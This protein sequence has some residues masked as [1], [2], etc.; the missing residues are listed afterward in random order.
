[1][2]LKKSKPEPP[3]PNPFL[4][5]P[6]R[7]INWTNSEEPLQYVKN[8]K[9]PVEGQK[10]RVLLY[11]PA[12]AGKSSFVNS[13]QSVLL[14]RM[15]NMALVGSIMERGFTKKVKTVLII[16]NLPTSQHY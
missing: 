3:K 7:K 16:I 6:W 13:I 15:Y 14:G 11:G 8:Y 2:G 5:T 4:S 9:P 10:I 1:M 12:G